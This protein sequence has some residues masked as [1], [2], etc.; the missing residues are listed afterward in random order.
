[1]KL[2]AFLAASA[3]NRRPDRTGY[4][5]RSRVSGTE[6]LW[7]GAVI[8]HVLEG[9][10]PADLHRAVS[11]P[12]LRRALDIRIAAQMGLTALDADD[13]WKRS[14]TAGP[15]GDVQVW[16]PGAQVFYWRKAK[17]VKRQEV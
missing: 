14:M 17:A 1:M 3:K 10:S 12:W 4:S 11:D 9:E 16:N 7:P 8:D 6:E 5:A 2:V 15:T 13:R